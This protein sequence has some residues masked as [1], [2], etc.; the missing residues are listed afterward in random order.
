[1]NMNIG[2]GQ[3]YES[4]FG[5]SSELVD[6]A[7]FLSSTAEFQQ[8][9]S[10]GS[11]TSESSAAKKI[12]AGWS[13]LPTEKQSQIEAECSVSDFQGELSRITQ[14]PR[15]TAHITHS[16][17]VFVHTVLDNASNS[18]RRKRKRPNMPDSSTEHPE[19]RT[20]QEKLNNVQLQSWPM[21]V[22]SAMFIRPPKQADHNA[23]TETKLLAFG[24]DASKEGRHALVFATVYNTLSWGHRLLSRSSQH[25]LLSSQSLG[26]LFDCIPCTSN[27]MAEEYVDED[28]TTKWKEP[29]V[30]ESAG[31]VICIEDVAY[32][33]GQ[34]ED[35]YSDKLIDH[36]KT[37]PKTSVPEISKG[38]L[39]H[40]TIF[41]TLPIRLHKPYWLLHA[42]DCEHFIVFE[43]IRLHHQSDPPPS[44][45][46]LT[47][48]MT[49]PLLDTCRACSKAPA[50]YA[51]CGDMRLG[52]SPFVICAPCWRWMGNP[53]AEDAH[54]IS[55]V[56]LPKH[57]LGWGGQ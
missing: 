3:G 7:Q 54:K 49:P 23:L 50:V 46:P 48:Q 4:Y 10:S 20:L 29:A 32:G 43:H 36:L 6:I 57:E 18:N 26:D 42:G 8:G 52:E 1:M 41:S 21:M 31:A 55:V 17:H 19:V 30:R 51:V 11:L 38:P 53:R 56:P 16:Y 12:Q 39:M 37:L 13:A 44:K 14:N 35:D 25:V 15:L 24:G 45:F 28:G 33:D 27:E 22:N 5:P 47:T 9:S 40:D 2:Q 34:S